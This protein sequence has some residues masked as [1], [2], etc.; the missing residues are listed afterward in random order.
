MKNKNLTQKSGWYWVLIEGYN[1]Y[2]PG[3]YEYNTNVKESYFLPGGIGD[4]S[5]MGIY[6]DEIEEIGPEITQPFVTK[7]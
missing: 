6:F 3:W 1:Q 7:N 5:S 4:E 2:L